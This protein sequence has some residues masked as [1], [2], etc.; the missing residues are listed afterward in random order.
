MV[1]VPVK[2]PLTLLSMLGSPVQELFS[3][4]MK[5]PSSGLFACKS[6]K[7]EQ[8]LRASGC[9]QDIRLLSMESKERTYNPLKVSLSILVSLLLEM[10]RVSEH[11]LFQLRY[12]VERD[13]QHNEPHQTRE[14][15]AVNPVCCEFVMGQI[16]H[17][18]L[19]EFTEQSG[20]EHVDGVVLEATESPV[21]Q[22]ADLA[23]LDAQ[24]AQL[25]QLP[26]ATRT[27][28]TLEEQGVTTLQTQSHRV[29]GLDDGEVGVLQLAVDGPESA[30][31]GHIVVVLGVRN[32]YPFALVGGLVAQRLA[33]GGGQHP[34]DGAEE[35]G[36]NRGRIVK[37]WAKRYRISQE[38]LEDDERPGRSVEV[39]M[40]D[41]VIL[42]EELMGDLNYMFYGC[43]KHKEASDNLIIKLV[44]LIKQGKRE[45]QAELLQVVVSQIA[46]EEV[47]YLIAEVAI[48][49]RHNVRKSEEQKLSKYQ[50]VACELQ[51]M[52][53]LKKV[54]IIPLVI[55]T[56]GIMSNNLL[57]VPASTFPEDWKIPL[58]QMYQKFNHWASRHHAYGSQTDAIWFWFDM[59][60]STTD[61]EQK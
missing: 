30:Y 15:C 59:V 36:A 49:L 13:I 26:E 40:E 16:Q 51:G 29:L 48:P 8:F 35:Q 42:V 24:L 12:P 54:I 60:V 5:K 33:Q 39:I 31:E 14:S 56:D 61:R 4:P 20:R 22:V 44:G 34:E 32:G 45:V 21:G 53:K 9:I 2:L 23:V 57:L 41:K 28:G 18:E 25:H 58:S 17:E 7:L 43:V 37:E 3:W 11:R 6:C 46:G 47:N 1:L 50:N 10:M 55:A 27:K 52:W 38:F 19:R